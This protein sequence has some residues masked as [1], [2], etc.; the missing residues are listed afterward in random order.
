MLK[1]RLIFGPVMIA[2]VLAAVWADEQLDTIQLTGKL[3]EL[4]FG[5]DYPPAGLLLLV[6]AIAIII[7]GS[8]EIT[9]IVRGVGLNC[10]RWLIS[11]GAIAGCL[12]IYA[13]PMMLG[14]PTGVSIVAT[15]LVA[16]FVGT[17]IWHSKDANTKGAITAAGM[18]MFG[19][20]L[21]GLMPGFYL[22]IRRWHSAWVVVAVLLI[23]KS[24]EIGAY[25][26]GRWF[27]KHKLIPWLSPKKT[28]EGLDN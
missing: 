20:A 9:A 4:F 8:R 28:W 24:C 6:V 25:F 1:Y 26:T 16:A 23:T 14:A 3:K 22:G 27:G 19:I 5:R 11:V 15:V 21:L 12:T 13:T 10:H 18:T 17:L 2:A 7:L